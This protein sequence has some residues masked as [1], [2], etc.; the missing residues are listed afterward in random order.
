MVFEKYILTLISEKNVDSYRDFTAG[1]A[2]LPEMFP[3]EYRRYIGTYKWNL[4]N[5]QE[6]LLRSALTHLYIG[7]SH[8]ERINGIVNA[9]R[10]SDDDKKILL[11]IRKAYVD[12]V[13]RKRDEIDYSETWVK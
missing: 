3:D 7:S 2:T 12:F 5:E 4:S 13:K 11:K 9:G 6:S 1:L 8:I 10:Y